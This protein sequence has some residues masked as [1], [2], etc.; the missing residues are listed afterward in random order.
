MTGGDFVVVEHH[1]HGGGN[2][3]VTEEVVSDDG[4]S[5]SDIAGTDTTEPEAPAND[6]A[7]NPQEVA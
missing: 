5:I 3:N 2:W 4:V 1:D 7:D 6:N